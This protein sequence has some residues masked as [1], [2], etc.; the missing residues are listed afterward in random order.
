VGRFTI[1]AY[2]PQTDAPAQVT[3][4]K[5]S[6]KGLI[7]GIGL[8]FIA[9]ITNIAGATEH[10][11]YVDKNSLLADAMGTVVC[12]N[13]IRGSAAHIHLPI[14]KNHKKSVLISAA[15]I[16]FDK[17]TGQAFKHCQ[18]RPQNK[19]LSGVDIALTSSTHYDVAN[20]NKITQAEND[21]IFLML[22]VP[23]QQPAL[24]LSQKYKNKHFDSLSQLTLVAY[25]IHQ[26][27][28]I[29]S[30]TCSAIKPSQSLSKKL[31]LHN[32]D[33]RA[34]M[35]G[36]A[37]VDRREGKIVAIHGGALVFDPQSFA[38]QANNS[39]TSLQR[40]QVPNEKLTNQGRLVD[41]EVISDLQTFIDSVAKHS[42]RN[43]LY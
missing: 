9:S 43:K 2:R 3:D 40:Y 11:S 36:G 29:D 25:N 22:D 38:E 16:L 18:Y 13:K 6:I 23:L 33:A 20:T 15:H 5:S 35:S 39:K 19:R 8:S 31:L 34:G 17:Q 37:I 42:E 41:V 30:D 24:G 28:I 14:V 32:C 1:N 7:F 21:I 27:R 26:D 4:N 10:P 12:D